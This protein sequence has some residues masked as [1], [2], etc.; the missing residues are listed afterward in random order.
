MHQEQQV[1]DLSNVTHDHIMKPDD[2]VVSL[3]INVTATP[4]AFRLVLNPVTD[5]LT[6][7]NRVLLERPKVSQ[8]VQKL[9]A[10]YESKAFIVIHVFSLSLSQQPAP[11]PYP[12]P[13]QSSPRP[14]TI[15]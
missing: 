9:A 8:L 10:F 1:P 2:K 13:D 14:H 12:E 6:P 4:V 5:I 7:R 3:A 11:C 15:S